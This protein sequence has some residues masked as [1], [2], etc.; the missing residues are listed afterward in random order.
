MPNYADGL[1]RI[2]TCFNWNPNIFVPCPRM[3][4]ENTP[5]KSVIVGWVG[6]F[7]DFF[8][9]GIILSLLLRSP[10]TISEAYEKPLLG[11]LAM[12]LERKR[13]REK[14]L[15]VATYV[16]ACSPRAAHAIRS[17]KL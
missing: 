9:I 1:Y 11:E 10:C 15:I 17:D 13:E 4:F 6:G 3:N 7:P 12:S 2:F 14:T 5:T 16:S 8:W